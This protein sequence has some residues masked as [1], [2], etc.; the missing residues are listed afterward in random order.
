MTEAKTETPTPSPEGAATASAPTCQR[1]GRKQLNMYRVSVIPLVVNLGVCGS[2]L[3]QLFAVTPLTLDVCFE[4]FDES[5]LGKRLSAAEM[6]SR[7]SGSG[8]LTV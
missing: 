4:C 8:P 7:C 3:G 2:G 6:P 1:C 5:R